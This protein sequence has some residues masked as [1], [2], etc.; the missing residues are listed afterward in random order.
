VKQYAELAPAIGAAVERYASE[1]RNGSFPEE[2]HTY[3]MTD[4]ELARFEESLAE[5]RAG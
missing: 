2:K 4:E 1:V 3:A 5:V